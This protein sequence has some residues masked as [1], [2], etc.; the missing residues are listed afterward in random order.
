MH[1]GPDG[2]YHD[3]GDPIAGYDDVGEAAD[4]SDVGS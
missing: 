3:I 4:R 1:D 2:H